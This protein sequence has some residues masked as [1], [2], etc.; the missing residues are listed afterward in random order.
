MRV[1][2]SLQNEDA[3]RVFADHLLTLEIAS[4]LRKGKDGWGVWAINEDRLAEA[5]KEFE[6]YLANPNDERYGKAGL[7]AKQL[8]K[9][10]KIKDKTFQKNFVEMAETW[11]P[12]ALSA[13]RC[14]ITIILLA[15]SVTVAVATD[16]GENDKSRL[17]QTLLISSH[18]EA[19][20]TGRGVVH[21]KLEQV[22][23]GEAWRLFTP[24]LIHFDVIH[25]VFNMLWLL[26]FG[27][28]VEATRGPL[29]YAAL[30]L[31]TAA[32]SNIAQ[33]YWSG[34]G[35]GGMS[36]VGYALFGYVL[37]QKTLYHDH[38]L[39]LSSQTF[40][41]GIAWLV[42]CFTGIMGPVANVAHVVGLVSGFLIGA[43]P[44]K[45][46]IRS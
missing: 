4:S 32:A 5:K 26:V 23:Q 34:P 30:V 36:G 33:Y 46:N 16:F 8:R 12:P 1:I 29:L 11:S 31:A 40:A 3:A 10:E 24:I 45:V 17:Y 35:F 39:Q 6:L 18:E 42:L 43:I 22:R 38:R 7:E 20:H 37:A 21:P 13:K 19:P 27:R 28:M 41:M 2:G 14:P 25:L 44:L 9:E 15:A